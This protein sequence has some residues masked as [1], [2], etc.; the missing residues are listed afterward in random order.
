MPVFSSSLLKKPIVSFLDV[1]TTIQRVSVT[2][3]ESFIKQYLLDGAATHVPDP[4]KEG[5]ELFELPKDVTIFPTL[6]TDGFQCLS[7]TPFKFSTWK[8]VNR[9]YHVVLP[10]MAKLLL[11]VSKEQ[12]AAGGTPTPAPTIDA[13]AGEA[14]IRGLVDE[15]E[16]LGDY[17]KE[18]CIC[19]AC[20]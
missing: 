7:T 2:V 9:T 3:S 4:I 16:D 1:A 5:V 13:E 14:F 8:A 12:R 15:G 17:L 19:Y 18:Q 10:N 6:E 11:K 20:L